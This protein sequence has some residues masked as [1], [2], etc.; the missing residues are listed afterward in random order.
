MASSKKNVTPKTETKNAAGDE[1][2]LFV[3]QRDVVK[4][5]RR[6]ADLRAQR[7]QIEAEEAELKGKVL[8]K[9]GDGPGFEGADFVF[10]TARGSSVSWKAIAEERGF[11][12]ALL[13]KHTKVGEP[14]LVC[15]GP[16]FKATQA[17]A[18]AAA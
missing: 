5:A 9:I 7:A 3:A 4:M 12:K 1:K 8:A 18:A 13:E 2:K 14:H 11:E 15:S 10:S 16:L 17:P 6:L